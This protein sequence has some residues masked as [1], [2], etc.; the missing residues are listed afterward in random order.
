MSWMELKDFR[1]VLEG[2]KLEVPWLSLASGQKV[3]LLGP[4]GSGK[5]TFLSALAGLRPFEGSYRL[6]RKDFREYPASELYEHLVYLPQGGTLG[7]P[8][9]VFYVVLTGR[10]PRLSQG[11]YTEEDR[12]K[13]AYW[14]RQLDLW[15]LRERLFTHLSGGEKQRTL[16]ARALNREAPVLLLDEPLNGVDL[17]HQH[18]F[19]LLLEEYVR[20]RS[21]LALVVLHDLAL[22]LQYFDYFLLFKEGRLWFQGPREELSPA[23]L[24]EVLKVRVN[25]YSVSGKTLVF[26]EV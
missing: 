8:Y 6:G 1:V 22:A 13:T 2:F 7:L 16:L 4:N 18:A 15:D 20:K 3:A 19:F 11:K 10:Y 14:L 9:E 5:S 23:V 24:S 21:A 12:E 25:F 26:T 17:H